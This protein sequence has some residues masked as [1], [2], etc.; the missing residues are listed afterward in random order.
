MNN[1]LLGKTK[2]HVRKH[3]NI[4]L[5][6]TEVRKIYFVTEANYHIFFF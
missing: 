4:K 6:T 1:A 2:K 3:K 5:L